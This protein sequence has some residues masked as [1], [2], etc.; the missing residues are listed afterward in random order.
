M[1]IETQGQFDNLVEVEWERLLVD[2]RQDYLDI[3]NRPEP[4]HYDYNFE[5]GFEDWCWS[6]AEDIIFNGQDHEIS[7]K[8]EPM[9]V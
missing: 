3:W 5:D 8:V 7:D 2:Y 4:E 1:K 6:L 9:Y